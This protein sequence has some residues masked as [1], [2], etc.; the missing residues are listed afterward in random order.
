MSHDADF[1]SSAS[2]EAGTPDAARVPAAA[3]IGAG[4]EFEGAANATLTGVKKKLVTEWRLVDKLL[5]ITGIFFINFITALDSSATSTIQ[6]QVLSEFNAMTRAGLIGTVTYLLIA[7][8]RPIFT[9]ISDVFGHLQALALAMFLHTL[10]FVVCAA[11]KN[12]SAVFGGTIIS[13]LGQAGYGTLVSIILADILPIHLRGI[14]AAFVSIPNVTNYYLGV[15]VGYGLIGRWHWVYGLLAI[16]AI[17]CSLPAMFSLFRLDKRARLV[18]RQIE[19]ASGEHVPEGGWRRRASVGRLLAVA[20]ELDVPGLILICGGIIAILAP[21]GMQLNITYGWGSA[22]VLAPLCIGVVAL[23][24][25]VF[26]ER[27]LAPFPVVPFHLF[28]IRT[29]TCAIL[30]AIFFYYTSNVSLYYFNPFIQVTREVSARTAMLLQLG[31]TG[32][33]VGLF[34]GGWAMQFSRRYRR[35]AWAGWALWLLAVGLMMRSRGRL[36]ASN[37]EIAVVQTILGIGSGIVIG[38]VG[39]GIQAAVSPVDLPM[40]ITLY[41]MVAYLGGVLGEGTSTTIW[42][43]VLPAKLRGRMAGDVDVDMAINNITYFFELPKDQRLVVQDAY[44]ATQRIL[45]ICGIVAMLVAAI[46]MLGLAPYELSPKPSGG[47]SGASGAS[48]D[49]GSSDDASSAGKARVTA[50]ERLKRM[51]R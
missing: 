23:V 2:I 25:F 31:S 27:R 33:Y 14:V 21:L 42:V 48:G 3:A 12:F 16:L 5:I 38:C 40:A 51:L 20:M 6:P 50:V 19:Q 49:D 34:F 32:Y 7:G 35:W 1:K 44:V 45:T 24:F 13:V 46:A 37:A 9:K 30:A 29:F 26:Y 4:T 8:I 36:G 43:N 47:D 39:I 17:V 10:G 28:R 15:E 18:L 11:A 22:R 41:G